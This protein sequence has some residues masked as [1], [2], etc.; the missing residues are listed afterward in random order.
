MSDDYQRLL[1]A[2]IDHLEILKSRGT[3]YVTVNSA[4]LTSLSQPA[5]LAPLVSRQE[6]KSAP[7]VENFFTPAQPE[8]KTPIRISAG[9][10]EK[11]AA[12]AE[13][14]NRA[15]I[16]VKCPNLANTRKN[17]VFGV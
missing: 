2:T 16:C 13:L 7:V 11:Y 5:Q 4:T 1:S 10:P 8:I 14:K 3:N 17:V 9:T 15:M 6:V 12:I